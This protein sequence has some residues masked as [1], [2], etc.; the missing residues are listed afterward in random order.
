[1]IEGQHGQNHSS[2]SEQESHRSFIREPL[3]IDAVFLSIL[4]ERIEDLA[5]Q[6]GR[7][8]GKRALLEDRLARLESQ[9]S[10]FESA[11]VALRRQ[12]ASATSTRISPSK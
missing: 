3:A 7:S 12:A 10:K 9:I 4:V 6:L 5:R 8:E 1:M 2:C 11:N